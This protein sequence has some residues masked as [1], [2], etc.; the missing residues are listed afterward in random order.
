VAD[1]SGFSLSQRR[2]A[3]EALPS[4]SVHTARALGLRAWTVG[5]FINPRTEPATK[6]TL[7]M[8]FANWLQNSRST[9]P[10][11]RVKRHG[12]WS[13]IYRGATRRLLRLELLEDRT[14]LSSVSFSLPISFGVGPDVQ[15]E[16]V[17]VGDFNS[18]GKPDLVTPNAFANSVSVLLGKGD[19]TLQSAQSYAVGTFPVSVAVGDFN[20]DD[21]PDLVVANQNSN[22]V[23][24]LLGNGD[25]TFQNAMNFDVGDNPVSVAV[26]DLNVDHKLDVAVAN[27]L[28]DT[29]SVLLGNGDGTLQTP[30]DIAVGRL[31]S[32]LLIADFNADGRPDLAVVNPQFSDTVSVL[33]GNGDGTF[34]TAQSIGIGDSP[35]SVA[36]GD[37]NADGKLDIAMSILGTPAVSVLLGNGDGTF[38]AQHEF[39][40]SG[41]PVDVTT[42]DF[43]GDG[44]LDLAVADLVTNNV[45]VLLG[46][47]DGTFQDAENFPSGGFPGGVVAGDFDGDGKPDLAVVNVLD[48]NVSVLLNEFVTTTAVSGPTSS[49]YGQPVTYTATVQSGAAPVT[50]GIVTFVV[51]VEQG[52]AQLIA[53]LPL[54]S[55]GQA[56]FSIATL[57]AGGYTIS[58]EYNDPPVGAGTAFGPSTGTALLTINPASLAVTGINFSAIAGV[59]FSGAIATFANPD[60]SGSPASFGAIITWGDGSTSSGTITGSAT[61]TV[62][63]GNTYAHPGTRA[64]TVQV[65]SELSNTTTPTISLTASVFTLVRGISYW[66]NTHGQAL[67]D[68]FNGGSSA[69]ALSSWLATSFPNLYGAGAGANNLTGKQNTQVAAFYKTQLALPGSNVEAEVLATAL[70]VYATTQSLGGNAAKSHHFIVSAGGLGADTFNVGG[71]GAAFGVANNTAL[72]VFDLLKAVSRQSVSGVLYNGS[73]S[74]EKLAKSLFQALNT[75]GSIS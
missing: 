33:L 35:N 41:E 2:E 10:L 38:Q 69:T 54:D 14:L 3:G 60:P 32:S 48:S 17:A 53:T 51:T 22:N 75:P 6:E 56:A 5:H 50:V 16:T 21:K 11:G 63:G 26:G 40:V 49:S 39:G 31:P 36:V 62:T 24:V 28:S 1:A 19:G 18:D 61:L 25:G 15:P 12:R 67:I 72:D 13:R 46:N 4:S 65:F 55:S 8:L 58:A 27:E 42:A 7:T 73:K 57:N 68:A 29:V 52:D 64:V 45:S 34:Q 44:K 30:Q 37:F 74:L 70:N 59:P 23:S 47:G 66:N 20:G 9:G 71:D 43:N